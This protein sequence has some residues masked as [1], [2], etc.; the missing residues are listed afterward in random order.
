MQISLTHFYP[1][2]YRA[3]LLC[4]LVTACGLSQAQAPTPSPGFALRTLDGVNNVGEDFALTP[5]NNPDSW[6]GF[7]YLA[8][9]QQLVAGDCTT[10]S[11]RITRS[12]SAPGADRGRFISA[13]RRSSGLPLAAF[14]DANQGNLQFVEC[15]QLECLTSV[16]RTLEE[17]GNVGA[18][19]SIAVDPITGFPAVAYYDAGNEDLRFY[20][21]TAADCSSGSAVI[22]DSAGSVGAEPDLKF[23]N[24]GRVYIAY[25][26][27]SNAG[28]KV[29]TAA[30]AAG[31]FSSGSAAGGSSGQLNVLNA[32]APPV[33]YSSNG[34]SQLIQRVCLFDTCDLGTNTALTALVEGQ[35]PN[36]TLLPNGNPLL[37]HRNANTGAQLATICTTPQCATRTTVTLDANAGEGNKS[38]ALASSDGLPA[39]IY[40]TGATRLM[41]SARCQDSSC[42][43]V[44]VRVASNGLTTALVR[45]ALSSSNVPIV[46]WNQAIDNGRVML[47]VCNAPGCSAP[48]IRQLP[49]ANS[50]GSRP[51]VVVRQALNNRPFVY[52]TSF[53]GTA[54]YDCADASCSSGTE[55]PISG[56]GTSNATE[57]ALRSDG[58]PV[59]LY[60]HRPSNVISVF[61][62]ADS[63]CSSGTAQVLVDEPDESVSGTSVRNPALVITA[64][65]RPAVLYTL[66]DSTAA[67]RRFVRCNQA[68]CTS[69]NVDSIGNGATFFAL[70]LARRSD[71]RLAFIE[72]GAASLNYA[73]C[74]S[75]DC[76]GVARFPLNSNG[77]PLG[78]AL[79]SDNRPVYDA[80]A[81]GN[82]SVFNCNTETCSNK[83]QR[84]VI[85]GAFTDMSLQYYGPVALTNAGEVVMGIEEQVLGDVFLAVPDGDRIFTDGFE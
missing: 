31:S 63:A 34:F 64:N 23:R 3:A 11:C 35:R 19:T 14:Y 61:I 84:T 42:G 69:V 46:A 40:R 60:Y 5:S 28:V 44:R 68:A 18:G 9:R 85:T 36:L 1:R 21:C 66:V 67:V 25:N 78:L 70:P 39:A 49:A 17:T 83:T 29:A 6:R 54:A 50:S 10:A 27:A 80:G 12:L 58:R 65:D 55:R 48:A 82:A 33:L 8:D 53:G 7:F 74:N 62:C 81:I 13:T 20:R 73:L 2:C 26:D 52:Y 41:R 32:P 16:E 47:A 38:V 24:D 45:T 22:V 51:G 15:T 4:A 72:F 43:S 57:V 79:R 59:L 56:S 75:D 37:T 77:I 71:A 76:S 30:S